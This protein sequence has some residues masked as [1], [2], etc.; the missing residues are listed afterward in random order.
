[1]VGYDKY[2]ALCI[3]CKNDE[4][5]LIENVEYHTLLGVDHFII[6]DNMS[7]NPLKNVFSKYNNVTV[8]EWF[9]Q[10]FESQ[11]RCYNDCIK[12]FKTE[13]RWIGFIDT[14]ELI[15]IKDTSKDIKTFLRPYETYGGLGVYW[16]CFGSSGHVKKQKSMIYSYLHSKDIQANK[17]FKSIVNPMSVDFINNPHYFHYLE[18]YYCV[19]ELYQKIEGYYG[20]SVTQEKIQLN[21]YVTRSREEFEYKKIRGGGN[22][23]KNDKLTEKFW[24]KYQNGVLDLTIINYINFKKKIN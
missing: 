20:V 18:G 21:H 6:Y 1:M 2:I 19:N 22:T 9:D 17:N 7:D 4:E 14:D 8:I 12:K 3:M 15:V 10:E 13:F 11:T 24:N 16:K 23:R 5:A